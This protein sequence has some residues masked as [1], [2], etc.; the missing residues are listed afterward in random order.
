MRS[1]ARI[2]LLTIVVAVL[3]G[4]GCGTSGNSADNH[5]VDQVNQAQREFARTVQGLSGA[6]TPTASVARRQAALGRFEGAVSTIVV[7]FRA[8]KP[9]QKVAILHQQLISEIAGFGSQVKT[10]STAL[11]SRDRGKLQAASARLLTETT[12]TANLISATIDAIN[13]KLHG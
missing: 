4:S 13:K 5:Y 12:A 6:T 2:V 8:I 11:S 7:R 10:A 9:P 1:K 3:A